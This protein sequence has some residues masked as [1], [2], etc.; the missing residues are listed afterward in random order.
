M[1]AA[2]YNSLLWPFVFAH[3]GNCDWLEVVHNDFI[4]SNCSSKKRFHSVDKFCN[5]LGVLLRAYRAKPWRLLAAGQLSRATLLLVDLESRVL[6][7]LICEWWWLLIYPT[8]HD[9]VICWGDAA[10]QQ[11]KPGSLLMDEF[12]S[13][14]QHRKGSGMATKSCT[15]NSALT[16][17]TLNK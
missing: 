6:F 14:P 17:H 7:H 2:R 10:R 15:L 8:K 11:N 5:N 4:P 13:V 16:E 1:N 12:K 9:T 3:L